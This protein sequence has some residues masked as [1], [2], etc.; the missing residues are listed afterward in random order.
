MSWIQGL[1]ELGV[2]RI[3]Q[4][5]GHSPRM[6]VIE[7]FPVQPTFIPALLS[8]KGLCSQSTLKAYLIFEGTVEKERMK[9]GLYLFL[10]WTFQNSLY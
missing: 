5:R 8:S 7:V 9:G 1:Q 6:Q 4:L 3:R 2:G 10:C